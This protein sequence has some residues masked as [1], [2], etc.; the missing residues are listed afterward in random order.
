MGWRRISKPVSTLLGSCP[1]CSSPGW[2][3]ERQADPSAGEHPDPPHH[4][5][6]AHTSAPQSRLP[7]DQP[8]RFSQKTSGSLTFQSA[9]NTLLAP[10]LGAS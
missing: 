10:A 6:R 2:W 3:A 9:P 4:P 8:T 1:R 7:A 5:G